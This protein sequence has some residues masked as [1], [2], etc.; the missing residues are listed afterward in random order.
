MLREGSARIVAEF[1]DSSYAYGYTV[2]VYD[3]DAVYA[4]IIIIYRGYDTTSNADHAFA[5]VEVYEVKI[6]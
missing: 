4:Y 2:H 6:R 5:D 3:Y 1:V